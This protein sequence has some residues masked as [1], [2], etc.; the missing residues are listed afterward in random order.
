MR[1][2]L[3]A[4]PRWYQIGVLSSLFLYGS[5]VLAFGIKALFA[6]SIIGSA[7]LTQ[8]LAGK[9]CGLP[10]F[11]PR[12]AFITSLSLCLL[13]RTDTL[14][15]A[16]LLT[17]AAVGSK[18]ILRVDGR[19]V[20][21]PANF[22]LVAGAAAG[23]SWVSPG[24]W[25]NPAFFGFLLACLGSLVVSRAQRLDSV[26]A[27]LSLYSLLL[28]GRA[29]WLGDPWSIPLHQLHSGAFLLF[30]FFMLSDPPT[31]PRSRAG[32]II[33]AALVAA[34]AGVIQFVYYQPLALLWALALCAPAV[35]LLNRF[36]PGEFYQ[37]PGGNLSEG[38]RR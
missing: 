11:D 22:A 32:R 5:L 30:T 8:Y 38:E 2:R 36:L 4:D 6:F 31:L 3:P 12:S 21:N 1:F 10:R 17:T 34:A 24:Q 25:G 15:A 33:H 37:W 29:W 19:H 9:L 7:L 27:F 35:V 26:L 16:L 18:F 20:F 13:L 14:W 23:I 28:F